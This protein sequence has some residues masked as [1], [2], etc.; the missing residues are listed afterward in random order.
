MFLAELRRPVVQSAAGYTLGHVLAQVGVPP[1]GG[2][3]PKLDAD[4]R[5][6]YQNWYD[7]GLQAMLDG[8]QQQFTQ[9]NP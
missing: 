6:Y 7:A 2:T 8:F 4:S 5:Q 3:P 9:P 1:G